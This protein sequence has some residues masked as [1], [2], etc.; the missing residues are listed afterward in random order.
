MQDRP[1][2][3]KILNGH[4][5]ASAHS[6]HLYSAHRAVIFAIAQLSCWLCVWFYGRVFGDGGSM[7]GFSESA[8]QMVLF[9]V[10]SNPRWW[11]WWWHDRRYRQE[12][13]DVAFCQITLAFVVVTRLWSYE[14]STGSPHTGLISV[15]IHKNNLQY[16]WCSLFSKWKLLFCHT[17]ISRSWQRRILWQ[18][19]G[20]G[21]WAC[22]ARDISSNLW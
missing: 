17:I 19:C 21:Y 2:S 22:C 11:P 18:L 15:G 7:V 9:L 4:I 10:W 20:V 6:I 13:S 12:M 5:S 8:G 3:W 16:G 1:P 14:E